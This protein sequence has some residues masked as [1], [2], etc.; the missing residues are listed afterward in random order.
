[1]EGEPDGSPSIS[2]R[3]EEAV[4][5]SA[6][7]SLVASVMAAVALADVPVSAA[8]PTPICVVLRNHAGVP[9][10]V[11]GQAIQ[12]V[13][14]VYRPLGIG[15]VWIT[16]AP[17][18]TEM[19]TLHLSILPRTARR[20]GDDRIIGVDAPAGGAT[21]EHLAH[22][23]YRRIGDDALTARALGHVMAQL[24]AGVLRSNGDVN[25]PPTIVYGDRR[26]AQRMRAGAPVF[27]PEEIQAILDG[28]ASRAR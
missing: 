9:R 6:P 11:L 12:I 14:D 4:M 13:T 18:P 15:I 21:P 10:S 23:L 16:S 25:A 28:A 27:T 20:R 7:Y 17:L 19:T 2:L 5:K 22:I 8:M 26:V 1:M 3:I 24:I